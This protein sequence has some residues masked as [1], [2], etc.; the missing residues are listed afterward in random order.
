MGYDEL[1]YADWDIAYSKKLGVED[2][3][4]I[5]RRYP[6]LTAGLDMFGGSNDIAANRDAYHPGVMLRTNYPMDLPGVP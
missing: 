6:S 3:P 2:M 5:M 4:F 1:V